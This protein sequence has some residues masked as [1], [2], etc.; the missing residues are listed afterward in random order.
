[1]V[2]IALA[3]GIPLG[4]RLYVRET[5]RA[6]LAE[7]TQKLDESEPGWTCDELAAAHNAALP[8]DDRNSMRLVREVKAALPRDHSVRDP[9]WLKQSAN[10]LPRPDEREVLRKYL[11]ERGSALVIARRLVDYPDG[12]RQVQVAEIPIET[13]LNEVQDTRTAA[14]ILKLDALAAADERRP[15]DAIRDVRAS[16]DEPSSLSQLIRSECAAVACGATERVIGLCEPSD[17]LAEL[18]TELLREADYPRLYHSLRAERASLHQ[19]FRLLEAGKISGVGSKGLLERLSVIPA[20]SAEDH[21]CGLG[22]MTGLVEASRR[23]FDEQWAAARAVPQPADGDRRYLYT[24]LFSLS[25]GKPVDSA[26]RTRGW[27]LA[28]AAGV[29]CER[30]RRRFGRWP[31][32]LDA[33]PKDILAA[34]PNDPFTGKPL[35]F[36]RLPDGVT[37]YSVGPDGRDDGGRFEDV[38]TEPGGAKTRDFGIRLWDPDKRRRPPP[39]V[40]PPAASD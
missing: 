11:A 5:D 3:L 27:L 15:A 35:T 6:R 31:D 12:G 39:K 16:G 33:I 1:M 10:M 36:R 29:A 21:V 4:Y 18:Q 40:D 7:M 20:Y 30:Y 23:P 13:H 9:D 24:L 34:V 32:S 37:V 26:P 19:M 28:T 14:W 17:G 8:P 38:V 2:G 25:V 22:M